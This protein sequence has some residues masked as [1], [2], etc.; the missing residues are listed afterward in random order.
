MENTQIEEIIG[1]VA[2]IYA[3]KLSNVLTM[4]LGSEIKASYS[5]AF[6]IEDFLI[7]VNWDKV[8]I[9]SSKFSGDITGELY[10]F[11]NPKNGAQ[12]ADLMVMGDGNVEFDEAEHVDALQELSNQTFGGF[13]TDVSAEFNKNFSVESSASSVVDKLNL[14]D[15]TF[16]CAELEIA[17]EDY[18]IYFVFSEE[19]LIS[20]QEI[21]I[22]AP[23]PTS[24]RSAK[25]IIENPNL[26]KILNT[27]LNVSILYGSTIMQISDILNLSPESVVELDKH[28]DEL[29]D[30]Y[31]NGK[32][33]A[34]GEIVVVEKN[35][36]IEIKKIVSVKERI[37]SLRE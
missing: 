3:D 29:V 4:S 13:V 19:I 31:V 5:N 37:L 6:S 20:L 32:I 16:Y 21:T 27:D 34:R 17:N 23:P 15:P 14:P 35:Y 30:I 25:D 26:Q 33:F 12:L 18:K 28:D 22:E 8:V 11:I 1:K 7:N 24:E 36:G 2:P 9:C 10:F